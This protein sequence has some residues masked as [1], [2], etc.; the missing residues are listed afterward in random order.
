MTIAATPDPAL[1]ARNAQR[2]VLRGLGFCI[3][4]MVLLPGQDAVAKYVSDTVSPGQIGW[5]RFALQTLFTLPF[6]VYFKGLGGLIPKRLWP[7]VLRGLLIATSSTLFFTAI[8]FMPLAD[9]LAIFFIEP[10]V[11]TIL[12]A[13]I[14]KEHV[15]WRRRIAVAAGFVGVLI[16]VRPSYDVFGWVSLIPALGGCIFA[17]YALMNRRLAAYDSPLTMQFTAGLSAWAVMTIAL[18]FGGLAGIPDLSP[19]AVGAHEVSLLLLMGVF[20]TAGHLLFVQ[21]GRL[22]PSSL[23]APMQYVEIVAAALLGYLVFGDFPDF[24]KWVGIGIIVASG[25]YV[26]W[27]ESRAR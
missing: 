8:K 24:W 6:L 16:V 2:D 27:R 9:A 15:G 10:F 19:S 22:A 14:D 13:V 1:A 18:A 7:N 26:F 4:A 21:A 17:F 12:S 3:L 11:L 5:A 23:I 20:G 25:G